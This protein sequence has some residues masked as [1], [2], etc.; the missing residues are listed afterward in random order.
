M[1]QTSWKAVAVDS[2]EISSF[3]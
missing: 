2:R 3:L 1:E